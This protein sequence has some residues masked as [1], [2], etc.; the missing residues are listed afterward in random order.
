DGPKRPRRPAHPARRRGHP[1]AGPLQRA[2]GA[3]RVPPHAEGARAE[4]CADR[5]PTVG[6]Q[7]SEREAAAASAPEGGQE[8]GDRGPRAKGH[9]R[10]QAPRGRDRA[11]PRLELTESSRAPNTARSIA[12]YVVRMR[13][14]IAGLVA[15]F[16][17][18]P[19][20]EVLIRLALDDNLRDEG[21]RVIFPAA[22][23]GLAASLC[24]IAALLV[25]AGVRRHGT[26]AG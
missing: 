9:T 4:C 20:G 16:V 11:R 8:A 22:L 7:A 3:V 14:P 10:S 24:L 17:A 13:A 25:A 12:G 5:A 26:A 15:F 18:V 2:A 23:A 6:R 21:V 19:S 1:R